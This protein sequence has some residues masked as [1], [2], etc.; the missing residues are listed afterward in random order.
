MA[1]RLYLSSYLEKRG[2]S[3]MRDGAPLH[4]PDIVGARE[5]LKADEDSFFV[6]ALITFAS[7]INSI[8]KNNYSWAFVQ[9]Y[10]ALFYIAKSLLASSDYAVYYQERK[11]PFSIKLSKGEC[12]H[13]AKGNSHQVV[14]EL[15][16]KVFS[17]NSFLMDEI[18]GIQA[19]DWFEECRNKINYRTNPFPD[20]QA[21]MPIYAYE[22]DLRK[23]VMD[24]RENSV[25]ATDEE[26]AYVAYILRLLDYELHLY[27]DNDRKNRFLTDTVIA[28]LRSNISDKSGPLSFYIKEL[29]SIKILSKPE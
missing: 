18:N 3:G 6:N 13:K 29:T 4:D 15:Y 28:H 10:Y 26:H 11:T 27:Q 25:Y 22:D 1:D 16:K 14:L 23:K 7:C 24:Y 9:S 12:F 17:G 20:P 21:P 2:Y 5:S 8:N 19:I